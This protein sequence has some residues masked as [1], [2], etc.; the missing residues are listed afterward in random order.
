MP[1]DAA[2]AA[3]AAAAA[4]AAAAAD[5]AAAG[6]GLRET[7]ALE[8]CINSGHDVTGTNKRELPRDVTPRHIRTFACVRV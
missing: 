3:A 1:E 8:R 6:H 7:A 2:A 4:T 5:A